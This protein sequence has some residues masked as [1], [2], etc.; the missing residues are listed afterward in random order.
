MDL[1]KNIISEEKFNN[2][3][4]TLLII[5]FGFILWSGYTEY[6]DLD[7]VLNTKSA[8]KLE[9]L[10][11]DTKFLQVSK[12][13][14]EE[15]RKIY[16]TVLALE[17]DPTENEKEKIL[18]SNFGFAKISGLF[19]HPSF[20]ITDKTRSFWKSQIYL[21]FFYT[22]IGLLIICL[23]YIILIRKLQKQSAKLFSQAIGQTFL[24][25]SAFLYLSF[26][27]DM[28]IY[29][30]LMLFLNETYYLGESITGGGSQQT[31]NIGMAL[32]FIGIIIQRAST[33]QEEQDLTI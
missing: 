3:I 25:L 16:V 32:F 20:L 10:D 6:N 11:F 12:I 27:V 13:Y 22:T 28:I 14:T 21:E 31:L 26:F 24:I 7:K 17:E 19:G 5:L 29:G 2:L 15:D 8:P 9:R 1:T 33:L 18:Q 30:R 23:V 4:S